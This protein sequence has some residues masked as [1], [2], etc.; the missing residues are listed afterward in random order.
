MK[1]SL[2]FYDWLDRDLKSVYNTEKGVEL[3]KTDFHSGSTFSCN[4][5]LDA[6]Q[7]NFLMEAM[8]TGYRPVFCGIR[9]E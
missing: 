6:E 7:E 1:T 9:K 2:V 5:E 3:S 4:I 8:I